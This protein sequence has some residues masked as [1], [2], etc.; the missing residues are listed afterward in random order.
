[1]DEEAFRTHDGDQL[2]R[3]TTVMQRLTFT[4]FSL[5]DT[6]PEAGDPAQVKLATIFIPNTLYKTI[7]GEPPE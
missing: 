6:P 3:P 7:V 5:Q 1:M 4:G 2:G